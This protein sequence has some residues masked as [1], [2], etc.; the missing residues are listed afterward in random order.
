MAVV[1]PKRSTEREVKLGEVRDEKNKIFRHSR[2]QSCTELAVFIAVKKKSS[3][4]YLYPGL[5]A[6][7]S[8]TKP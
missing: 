8:L 1:S 3:S 5:V 4:V 6:M 2:L 7:K